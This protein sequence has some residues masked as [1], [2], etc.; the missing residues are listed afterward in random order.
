MIKKRYA[1]I[2]FV[3]LISACA[4]LKPQIQTITLN[5]MVYDLNNRPIAGYLVS[6]GGELT[7][8][9]D[10][11]GRFTI[12]N[13]PAGTYQ[14]TGSK[15]YYEPYAGDIIIEDSKTVVYLSIP[16]AQQLLDSADYALQS[17]KLGEAEG[18]LNRVERTCYS[19]IDFHFYKAV[20]QFRKHEYGAAQITLESILA[21]GGENPTVKVFLNDLK[22]REATHE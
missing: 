22:N 15:K 4:T 5:G 2:F 21:I 19:N 14:I 16:S 7:V 13:V 11:T 6:L 17:N 10:I 9:T 3:G 1:A 12:P 8:T 18:Y 20:L